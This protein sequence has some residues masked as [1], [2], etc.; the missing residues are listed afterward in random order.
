MANNRMLSGG[1]GVQ[2]VRLFLLRNGK[3]DDNFKIRAF[4]DQQ[5]KCPFNSTESIDLHTEK[6]H[7][8]FIY[9]AELKLAIDREKKLYH[10]TDHGLEPLGPYNLCLSR[11]LPRLDTTY[12]DYVDEQL[13]F[14][15]NPFLNEYY[16]LFDVDFQKKTVDSPPG[17]KTP[18]WCQ[19]YIFTY[20]LLRYKM[21][22]TFDI[23]VE[24]FQN[25]ITQHPQLLTSLEL[26]DFFQGCSLHLNYALASSVDNFTANKILLR[27]IGVLPIEKKNLD[28]RKREIKNF[29]APILDFVRDNYTAILSTVTVEDWLLFRN[30]LVICLLFDLLTEQKDTIKLVHAIPDVDQKQNLATVLLKKLEE[31]QK[32]ILGLNWTSIFPLVDPNGLSLNSLELTQSMETYVTSLISILHAKGYSEATV[33]EVNQHFD[34]L[35]RRERLPGTYKIF[36]FSKN[37]TKELFLLI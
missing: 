33:T 21:Y 20:Y 35:V 18:F 6:E 23:L 16:F 37:Q 12:R 11:K 14:I 19:F 36:F 8:T 17:H 24:Q 3:S 34:D 10:Q 29:I 32:P 4:F 9:L 1:Y 5:I 31:F 15:A 26:A 22:N 2:P 13:R 7:Q 30:G 25:Q 28:L 27:M